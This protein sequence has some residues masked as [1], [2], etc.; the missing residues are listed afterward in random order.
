MT[1]KTTHIA[2]AS[3][4]ILLTVVSAVVAG[5]LSNRWGVSATAQKAAARLLETPQNVGDWIDPEELALS[6]VAQDV[7]EHP[8][9][10]E[11]RYVRGSDVVVVAVLV[12]APGPI[13]VHT[14]EICYSSREYVIKEDRKRVQFDFG[15]HSLWSTLFQ[16]RSLDAPLCQVVYGWSDGGQWTA[17]EDARWKN[18]GKSH[19]Y[20]IQAAAYS[21]SAERQPD[22][23]C[24]EFLEAFLPV[25]SQHL[26]PA[27]YD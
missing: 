27:T 24:Q 26:V 19:L 17:P 14:P 11:R 15:R 6:P 13:A 9:Y 4:V 7:L 12:G 16:S 5:R 20:K 25:L 8:T 21:G 3:A 2:A 10:L 23:V 18:I 1:M 22:E